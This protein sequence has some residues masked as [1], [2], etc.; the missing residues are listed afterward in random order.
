MEFNGM[1]LYKFNQMYNFLIE[2]GIDIDIDY[3]T[4]ATLNLYYDVYHQMEI[5]R[6]THGGSTRLNQEERNTYNLMAMNFIQSVMTLIT[7]AHIVEQ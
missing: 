2:Y 1:E 6:W 3:F 4:P 7:F 5:Y